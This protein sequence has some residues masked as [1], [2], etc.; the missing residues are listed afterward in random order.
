[1]AH[2]LIVDDNKTL[3]QTYADF[4]QHEG[5]EV[6]TASSV[7]EALEY[8]ALNTPDLILL[9]MLLPKV[10]GLELL[11]QYDIRNTHKEVKVIAF[12]NLSELRI[13]EEAQLLGVS[14]YL[15]KSRMTPDNLVSMI[16]RALLK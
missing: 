8:L 15:D 5:H 14:L 2:I 1:M 7:P 10:N 9:D 6:A 4:L 11:Q 16:D 3:Q 12:S 13:Q